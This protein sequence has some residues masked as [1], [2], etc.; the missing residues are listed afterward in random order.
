MTYRDDREAFHHRVAQLEDELRDASR[1]GAEEG[2]GETL[3]RTNALEDK[4][5]AMRAD[6]AKVTAELQAL[7]GDEPPKPTRSRNGVIALL[8]ALAVLLIGAGMA[9]ALLRTRSTATATVPDFAVDPVAP[10]PVVPPAPEPAAPLPTTP[11]PLEA[12]PQPQRSTTARWVAKVS[13]AEGVAL[14]AGSTCNVDA[15]IVTT[16]TNAVVKQLTVQ[17]GATSLYRSTDRLNGMSQGSNDAREG[18]AATDDKSS[19]TLAYRDL[20]T[21]TGER[22]QIDLD[23]K[24]QQATVFRD[25]IPRSRVDLTLPAN[26]TPGAP[27]ANRSR[28]T[29]LVGHVGG[30]A[31]VKTGATCVLRAM[32]IGKGKEC[33]ADLTC[34][35]ITVWLPT[36]PV[37][38]TYE[39]GKPVTVGAD[40]GTTG[41]LAI[42]D[43]TLTVKAKTYDLEITLDDAP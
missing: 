42:A 32:A 9:T 16:D 11:I 2:R 25:T 34:G 41:N 36:A 4:L 29:G 37:K 19:F 10:P 33:V 27:L 1:E 14:A 20:G 30:T 23:S 39:A 18:F 15:T 7:R 38:C 26:S 40:D 31:P 22:A 21:R 43:K 12:I 5:A 35:S 8:A 6:L 17:C 28:R 24:H 13:K 3:A